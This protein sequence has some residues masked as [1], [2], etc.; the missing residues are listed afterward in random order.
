[1]LHYLLL[2][3]A[4]FECIGIDEICERSNSHKVIRKVPV[5]GW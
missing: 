1:M 2:G 4:E 5:F 3:S